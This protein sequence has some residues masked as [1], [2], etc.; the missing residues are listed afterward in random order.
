[1]TA[2][3]L[4]YLTGNHAALVDEDYYDKVMVSVFLRILK[5]EQ[6]ENLRKLIFEHLP[7]HDD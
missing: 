2:L 6:D 4:S 7:S 5:L 1:M 3:Q